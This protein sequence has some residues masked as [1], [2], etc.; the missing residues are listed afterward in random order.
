MRKVNVKEARGS[1]SRLLDEANR[2]EK[3][4]VT[5]RG[6]GIACI[7]PTDLTERL[8]SLVQFRTS[9]RLSGKP[10]SDTVVEGRKEERY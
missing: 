5:R 3:I 7:V 1:L 2:G 8:P 4:I 9:I 6:K 10:L